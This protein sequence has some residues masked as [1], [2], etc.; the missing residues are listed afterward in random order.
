MLSPVDG[1]VHPAAALL[2]P[3]ASPLLLRQHPGLGQTF[4]QIL[5]QDDVPEANY[6]SNVCTS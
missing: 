2:D 3:E 5:R 4:G 6:T 1:V